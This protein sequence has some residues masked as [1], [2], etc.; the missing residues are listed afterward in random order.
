MSKLWQ[1]HIELLRGYPVVSLLGLIFNG[2]EPESPHAR[3][4]LLSLWKVAQNN[5]EKSSYTLS[6]ADEQDNDSSIIMINLVDRPIITKSHFSE[7]TH[8]QFLTMI[9]IV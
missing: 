2:P 4:F 7:I 1:V 5:L 6:M 9:R 8:F 3:Q